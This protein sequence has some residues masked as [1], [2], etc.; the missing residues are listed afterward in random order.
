[1]A[2]D[3]AAYFQ[4]RNALE[5]ALATG[6]GGAGGSVAAGG[7]GAGAGRRGVSDSLPRAPPAAPPAAAPA[8]VLRETRN[9]HG[10]GGGGASVHGA[11]F[12]ETPAPPK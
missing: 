8:A 4:A 2:T 9:P 12:L 1:M 6:G 7:S 3:R 10:G 11:A 5:L